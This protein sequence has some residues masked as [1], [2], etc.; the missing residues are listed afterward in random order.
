MQTYTRRGMLGLAGAVALVAL[1][2]CADGDR[3][4]TPR[5]DPAAE[6]PSGPSVELAADDPGATSYQ[7]GSL[8]FALTMLAAAQAEAGDQSSVV[9]PLSISQC[10]ALVAQGA[11]GETAGQL[12]A[13][14][15]CSSVDELRAGANAEITAVRAL[16]HA[17]FDLANA[18]FTDESFPVKAPYAGTLKEYFGVAAHTTDFAAPD[19]ATAAINAWVAGRTHEKIPKLLQ[20]GQVTT[21]TVTVLVNALYLKARWAAE[22]D[23]N[24]TAPETF[25]RGDGSVVTTDFMHDDR[26]VAV[27]Q[28]Q[29][30]TVFELAYQDDGLRAVFV[31][32]PAGMAMAQTIDGLADGSLAVLGIAREKVGAKLAI[33]VFEVRQRIELTEPLMGAGVTLAFDPDHADFSALSDEKT[34]VSFVQHEAWLKVAEKGTE[35]A[36]A[37][38]GGA[39]V[40]S[41]PGPSEEPLLIRLDRPFV[42][43]VQETAT[44]SYPFV[45]AINDPSS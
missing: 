31:L 19:A 33:P 1:A 2:A 8:A 3:P 44:G 12:A 42:F 16:Q 9:S 17:T 5:P 40:G 32:P 13:L 21:D 15:G 39:E 18:A 43:A 24:H 26:A 22:F 27:A 14:L 20:Q 37:T 28:S 11:R 4:R 38:A 23:P 10:L 30:A 36:A 34:H 45:A 41:A 35:G 25:T 6:D 7:G 29:G